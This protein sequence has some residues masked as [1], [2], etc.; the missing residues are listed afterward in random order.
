[1]V[2]IDLFERVEECCKQLE[3]SKRRFVEM[4]LQEAL[5]QAETIVAEVDPFVGEEH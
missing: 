3:L 5:R 1:M 4:A 2:S